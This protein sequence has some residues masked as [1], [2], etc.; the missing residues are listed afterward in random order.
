MS[1]RRLKGVCADKF[2]A[3]VTEGVVHAV[4]KVVTRSSFGVTQQ[5][6]V[7]GG[8]WTLHHGVKR[9]HTNLGQ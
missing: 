2:L 3:T 8:T 6:K 5:H 9:P 1:L 7:S 4:Y